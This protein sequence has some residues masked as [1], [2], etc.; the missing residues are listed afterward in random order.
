MKKY[1]KMK[2]SGIEWMGDVPEDWAVK[3][4]KHVLDCLNSKRIP[5]SSEVRGEM[6]NRE[7][8]YYGASG[9]IDKVEGFLF[10]ET[11]IL[12]GEDGAN[13]LS[14]SSP[15][16]FLA[17]GKFWVNNHAHILKPKNG[18]L[19]YFVHQLEL[20]DFTV[21]VT[22]SAQPKLTQE[23]LFNLYLLCPPVE[24]QTA[25]AHYLNR[26]TAQIDKA[27]AEKEGL[28]ELFREERQAIINHA[29]TKGIRA[30][31]KMKASGVAWIGDVPEGWEVKRV[32]RVC[33]LQG[34]IGFK[35]YS[36]TDLV[37]EG[38]GVLTLGAKHISKKNEL[39]LS[40]PEFLSWEKYYESPE[41]MVQQGHVIV[42][43]RGSL[44]K[45]VMIDEEIGAATIN[46]SM[47]LLK[48]LSID[49]HFFLLLL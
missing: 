49:Q 3:K 10:D 33:K 16:A 11:L 34:R 19:E 43:Q 45:V 36:K 29:V 12:I 1:P 23:N 41:I 40:S 20:N 13:L 27:I 17:K 47:I 35:G 22:G 26:K 25:I 21:F 14:R 44:G 4:L 5:L 31:V 39:D 2:S 42:T 30:G 32:K 37:N 46:P 18:G 7:Y 28:I 6:T 9:V 38:E 48:D 15:L 24:E 8:D